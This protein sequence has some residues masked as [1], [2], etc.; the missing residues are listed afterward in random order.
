[1]EKYEKS[2]DNYAKLFQNK[3]IYL[4]LKMIE[5]DNLPLHEQKQLKDLL[6][7]FEEELNS[8]EELKVLRQ[9]LGQAKSTTLQDI[10]E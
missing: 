5:K 9:D 3:K 1:M 2:Q 4:K 10:N 6:K 8:G 7:N